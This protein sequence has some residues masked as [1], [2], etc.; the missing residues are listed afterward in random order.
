MRFVR[1]IPVLLILVAA[2]ASAASAKTVPLKREGDSNSH[3]SA[4]GTVT[5]LKV[6]GKQV[7]VKLSKVTVRNF[8]TEWTDYHSF[9]TVV[10]IKCRPPKVKGYKQPP[11]F[12]SGMKSKAVV[13]L[14]TVGGLVSLDVPGVSYKCVRPSTFQGFSFAGVDIRPSL[15]NL[16]YYGRIGGSG[17]WSA[18]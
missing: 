17:P 10:T 2:P 13:Q 18:G 6:K 14:V 9:Y 5:A 8:A 12:I 3:G 1:V 11:A 15:Q 4:T 7:G 16:W